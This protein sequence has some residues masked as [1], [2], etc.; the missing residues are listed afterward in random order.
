MFSSVLELVVTT[1]N[2]DKKNCIMTQAICFKNKFGYCK[3]SD[4]C[5]YKHVTLVCEDGQ[6][7]IKNCE[8]RHP[9]ICK[10]YRDYRRCKFTVGCKYKHE[11][12]ND[13]FDKLQK[14]LE[15][16]RKNYPYN[17]KENRYKKLEEE[18]KLLK[19]NWT[20]SKKNWRIKMPTFLS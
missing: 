7:E 10:Y 6:C 17:E 19:E 14:E 12:P 9:K 2:F 16:I 18:L 4:S 3:F 15:I 20:L 5:R 13:K 8:K 11:N 1:P